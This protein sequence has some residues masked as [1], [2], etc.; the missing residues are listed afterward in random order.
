MIVALFQDNFLGQAP[1]LGKQAHLFIPSMHKSKQRCTSLWKSQI[2]FLFS[3]FKNIYI[4]KN[5]YTFKKILE[6]EKIEKKNEVLK[7]YT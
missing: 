5:I 6:S 3:I 1:F 7:N 2:T 4:L